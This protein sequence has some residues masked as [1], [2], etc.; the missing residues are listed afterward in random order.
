[1]RKTTYV[2]TACDLEPNLP[3]SKR[4]YRMRKY[5]IKAWFSESAQQIF[6]AE[7]PNML[8]VELRAL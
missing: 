1:M 4:Q 6:Y 7:H 2:I 8:I 3:P 5:H